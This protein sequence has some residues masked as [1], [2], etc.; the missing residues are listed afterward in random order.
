MNSI[1]IPS[2]RMFVA[3]CEYRSVTEAGRHLGSTQAAISQ[4]LKKLESQVRLQLIDRKQRPLEL[5][6]AGQIMFQRALKILA[7]IDCLDHDLSAQA[8]LPLPEL[9]L[10]VADTFGVALVPPLVAAVK[11]SFMQLAVRVD[12][13]SMICRLL[14]DRELHAV[15]S[16]DSLLE[17]DDLERHDL[18]REPLV[19]VMRRDTA[20]QRIN[21]ATMRWLTGQMPFIRYSPLSPLA[22]QIETHL[23]RMNVKPPRK[24]EFNASE[25]IMEMVRHGLGWTITTPLCLVQAQIS[26]DAFDI[27]KLPVEGVSRSVT[28]L[29]R[30]HELGNVPHRLS[31]L[32]R[33]IIGEQVVSRMSTD[34]PWIISQI[35]IADN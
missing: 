3:V 31:A 12:S 5:T 33:Q 16:S 14:L 2:L 9:R 29:A 20:P 15:V 24:M 13:S 35:Q 19:L 21:A 17:R 28:L 25:T 18:F 11:D 4:R 26:L 7:E 6:A 34:L 32:S 23:H 22:Q 1:D 8:N 10:G 27:R 30:Q